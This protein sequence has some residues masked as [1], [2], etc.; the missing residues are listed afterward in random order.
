MISDGITQK[1]GHNSRKL[2]TFANPT[3]GHLSK[4][5]MRIVI[6]KDT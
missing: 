5:I 1:Q 4:V 2:D 6:I 3:T